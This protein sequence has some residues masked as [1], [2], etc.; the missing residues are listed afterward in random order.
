M[1]K[2]YTERIALLLLISVSTF[3][4][5]QEVDLENLGKKTKEELKKNPFKISGGI[6]VFPERKSEPRLVQMVNA[7]IIQLYQS[8]K[9]IRLS[10]AI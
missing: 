4:K 7:N 5:A 6:Y 8:G 10:G 2:I 9:P 3:Y 1:K